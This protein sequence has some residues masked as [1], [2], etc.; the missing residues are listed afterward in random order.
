MSSR[1]PA[2]RLS[3][4]GSPPSSRTRR[5][6]KASSCCALT[7]AADASLCRRSTRRV[8]SMRIADDRAIFVLGDTVPDFA[9]ELLADHL[10]LPDAAPP[11]GERHEHQEGHE[12]RELHRAPHHEGLQEADIGELGGV[13]QRLSRGYPGQRG[14]K[15]QSVV[16]H[17]RQQWTGAGPRRGPTIFSQVRRVCS[18][19]PR[20]RA[21]D[22]REHSVP[23]EPEQRVAHAELQAEGRLAE[24]RIEL[25]DVEGRLE[26]RE[27]DA[28]E[29][30]VNEPV[31]HVVELRRATARTAGSRRA[32]WRSPRRSARKAAPRS[33]AA[34][35]GR[36]ARQAS[37]SAQASRRPA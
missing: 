5:L 30:A 23:T 1:Q 14:V 21:E 16:D 4:S 15:R 8:R 36:E 17:M 20:R 32:P 13:R 22:C 11:D 3:C 25:G 2:T 35:R 12:E 6:R 19:S 28:Y 33:S 18:A 24:L 10:P 29:R 31:A 26:P 27:A 34:R 9:R 7:S 37:G